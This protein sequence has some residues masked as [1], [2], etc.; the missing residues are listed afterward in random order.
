MPN[1][2]KLR[3]PPQQFSKLVRELRWSSLWMLIH[4]HGEEHVL[5]SGHRPALRCSTLFITISEAVRGINLRPMNL[6]TQGRHPTIPIHVGLAICVGIGIRSL[7]QLRLVR[8]SG[9]G[10]HG[11]MMIRLRLMGRNRLLTFWHR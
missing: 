2:L 7:I 6:V 9:L 5:L 11:M 8:L 3:I 4:G 10:L 1:G